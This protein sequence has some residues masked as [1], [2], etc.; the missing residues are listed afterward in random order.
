MGQNEERM[1]RKK[2]N[3][4]KNRGAFLEVLKSLGNIQLLSED[5]GR[6]PQ[7]VLVFVFQQIP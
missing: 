4:N 6:I 1:G 2:P 5:W 7:G 3:A